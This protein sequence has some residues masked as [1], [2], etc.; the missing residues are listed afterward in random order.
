MSTRSIRTR[1]LNVFAHLSAHK[2]SFA[3]G[4][5]VVDDAD[6]SLFKELCEQ[7][8]K[9]PSSLWWEIALDPSQ[10]L[11]L[12]CSCCACAARNDKK[13]AV[14]FRSHH[15]AFV[16][17]RLVQHSIYCSSGFMEAMRLSLWGLPATGGDCA[18]GFRSSD[19]DQYNTRSKIIDEAL[20]ATYKTTKDLSFYNR[21]HRLSNELYL[22]NVCWTD[23]FGEPG[24]R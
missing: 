17:F 8:L 11:Q 12:L 3:E 16:V 9:M 2:A 20:H 22:P 10:P 23:A 5:F 15:D 7:G 4:D 1:T 6:G 19:A 14:R 13:E 21:K 18:G 24:R